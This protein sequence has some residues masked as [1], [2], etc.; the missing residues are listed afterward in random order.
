VFAGVIA[1]LIFIG[2]MT[3]ED[4]RPAIVAILV[5]FLLG[6]IGFA[7]FGR[8]RLVLSPEEEYAMTGGLHG[9][10]AETGAPV[11]TPMT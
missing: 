1:T 3:N 2:V 7:R 5:V 4:Y 9:A 6:L 10:V 11:S 8:H